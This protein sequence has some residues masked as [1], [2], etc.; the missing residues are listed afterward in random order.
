MEVEMAF[1]S[2]IGCKQLATFKHVYVLKGDIR[3][4]AD[5]CNEHKKD[6]E[7]ELE[8]DGQQFEKEMKE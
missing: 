7:K 2:K 1:C 4:T 5:S 8:K 6:I 3:L